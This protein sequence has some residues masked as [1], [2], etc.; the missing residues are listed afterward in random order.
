MKKTIT[1]IINLIIISSFINSLTT[2]KDYS[3]KDFNYIDYAFGSI[4]QKEWIE[5]TNLQGQGINA[6]IIDYGGIE[7]D[8]PD[9]KDRIIWQEENQIISDQHGTEVTGIASGSGEKS[10]GKILGVAPKANLL[11]YGDE[12]TRNFDEKEITKKELEFKVPVAIMALDAHKTQGNL[13]EECKKYKRDF[14]DKGI[15]LVV[16]AGNEHTMMQKFKTLTI[17]GSCEESLVVGAYNTKTNGVDWWSSFGPSDLKNGILIK[18]DIV[19]SG[20][21]CTTTVKNS[22]SKNC[23]KT[24]IEGYE[25]ITGTSVATPIVGGA[26]ILVKQKLDQERIITNPDIL[27]S[28]LVNYADQLTD[29]DGKPENIYG[30]GGGKLNIPRAVNARIFFK[31]ISIT[32]DK[33]TKDYNTE[34]LTL[35]NY[36]KKNVLVK[37]RIE[38]LQWSNPYSKNPKNLILPTLKYD[39]TTFCLKA[40]EKKQLKITIKPGNNAN[41]IHFARTFFEMHET[42]KNCDS[43]GKLFETAMVP[44]AFKIEQ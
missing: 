12:A 14:Y 40:G 27:K 20:T 39:K 44:V 4:T 8:N 42:N 9:Y 30:Q 1:I 31:P 34:T 24:N 29:S 25:K 38:K 6:L 37:T 23:P 13:A 18:P 17:T 16:P 11:L 21:A 2:L 26:V 19:A 35:D 3:K 15:L 22:K 5:K 7:L 32:F 43:T 28:A 36:F 10:K 41:G 33:L